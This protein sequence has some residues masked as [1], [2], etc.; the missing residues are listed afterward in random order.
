MLSAECLYL[1]DSIWYHLGFYGF[2]TF[3]LNFFC[4]RKQVVA[5]LLIQFFEHFLRQA[6]NKYQKR[7]FTFL[8]FLSAARA[9][10]ILQEYRADS[11]KDVPRNHV[12]GI[13]VVN[14]DF[15]SFRWRCNVGLH[16]HNVGNTMCNTDADGRKPERR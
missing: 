16:L 4:K 2:K 7:L 3:H 12:S 8:T 9:C 10:S 1:Y 14:T 11:A 5:I 15:P 13:S 6:R